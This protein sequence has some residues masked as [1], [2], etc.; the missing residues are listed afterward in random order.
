MTVI[1]LLIVL[2]GGYLAK[3]I[4]IAVKGVADSGAGGGLERR[5]QVEE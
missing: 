1:V 5:R 3:A 4:G 2:R